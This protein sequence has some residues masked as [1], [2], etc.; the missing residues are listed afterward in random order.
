V[1]TTWGLNEGLTSTRHKKEPKL[2]GNITQSL[3]IA[4]V[5]WKNLGCS[6]WCDVRYEYFWTQFHCEMSDT[7]YVTLR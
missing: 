6:Q 3:V 1:P 5:T 7:D 2:I 4:W